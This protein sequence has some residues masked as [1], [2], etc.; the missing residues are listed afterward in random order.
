MVKFIKTIYFW[1]MRARRKNK[2]FI[3]FYWFKKEQSYLFLRKE[4]RRKSLLIKIWFLSIKYEGCTNFSLVLF[5]FWGPKICGNCLVLCVK[6]FEGCSISYQPKDSSLWKDISNA[7]SG[8]ICSWKRSPQSAHCNNWNC[9]TT[10][11]W[12]L[13]CLWEV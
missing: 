8:F 2:C 5:E 11:T 10:S 3:N 12:K 4:R 7:Y 9:I 13:M 1:L 6:T